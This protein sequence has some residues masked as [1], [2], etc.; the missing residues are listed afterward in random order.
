MEMTPR[1]RMILKVLI[2]DFVSDNKTCWFLKTLSE[3]YDIGLSLP[4]VQKRLLET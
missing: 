2:D 3:K 1:H 4:I